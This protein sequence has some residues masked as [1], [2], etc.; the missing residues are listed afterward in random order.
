MSWSLTTVLSLLE[1]IGIN[2]VLSGDNAVVVSMAIHR[3]APQHRRPALVFGMGGAMALQIFATLVVSWL[4]HIPLLLCAGGL[5]LSWI[6]LRLLRDETQ[7]ETGTPPPGSLGHAVWTIIVANCVM[8]LD[9]V[10][11]VASIGHGRPVL[12]VVGLGVSIV[13]TLTSSVFIAQWMNRYPFLVT[14]GAGILAW[15]GGRMIATDAVVS[16]AFAIQLGVDLKDGPLW[17][18]LSVAMTAFVLL[19]SRHTKQKTPVSAQAG[20]DNPYLS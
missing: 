17:F 8:S 13:L 20:T 5:A 3:L 2:I 15:T 18:T 7:D 11:A 4:F 10:L 14:L 6:A 12:I 1:I 16:H 9:N 19:A